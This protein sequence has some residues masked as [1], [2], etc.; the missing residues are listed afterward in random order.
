MATI[1]KAYI[2]DCVSCRIT[3]ASSLVTEVSIEEILVFPFACEIHHRWILPK[4]DS[5]ACASH[6]TT[7]DNINKC[8]AK[9]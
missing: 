3:N 7:F 9:F 6:E 1:F 2:F 4:F 8:F 5:F